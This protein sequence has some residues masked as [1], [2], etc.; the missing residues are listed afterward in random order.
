[1]ESG[2]SHEVES[3]LLDEVDVV[4]KQEKAFLEEIGSL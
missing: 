3:R 4:I 2:N 1:M